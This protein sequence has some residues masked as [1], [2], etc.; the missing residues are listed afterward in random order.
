MV[1]FVGGIPAPPRPWL[2]K[3][4]LASDDFFSPWGVAVNEIQPLSPA[5]RTKVAK[6]RF[7]HPS[8]ACRLPWLPLRRPADRLTPRAMQLHRPRV[9]A[10]RSDV[11]GR[12]ICVV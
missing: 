1:T 11:W 5:S 3:K 12:D 2:G 4:P 9:R 10:A 7:I 6:M 8:P